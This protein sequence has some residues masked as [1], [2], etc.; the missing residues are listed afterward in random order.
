MRRFLSI[1]DSVVQMDM[2]SLH[3]SPELW[4]PVD[5]N[6]FHP[7]R[8]REKRHR[9]AFTAFGCGPKGCVGQRFAVFIIKLTLVR[10]LRRYNILPGTEIEDRLDIR[11]R[12]TITPGAVWIRIQGRSF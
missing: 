10:L 3:Y 11:E 12:S 4:G 2:Y 8:H 6:L 9:L 7:D 5:P 1:V